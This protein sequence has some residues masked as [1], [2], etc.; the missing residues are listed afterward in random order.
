MYLAHHEYTKITF[1]IYILA[2]LILVT[3][4]I[5]CLR[6]NS[7]IISVL[8]IDDTVGFEKKLLIL[9]GSISI[10]CSNLAI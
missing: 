1:K 3:V 5:L 10:N 4:Y 2:F 6:I 8:L 7:I 9:R